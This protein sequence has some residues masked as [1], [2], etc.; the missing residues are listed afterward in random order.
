LRHVKED[1]LGYFDRLAVEVKDALNQSDVNVCSWCAEIWVAQY[2]AAKAARLI[3]NVRFVDDT[4]A[5][6]PIDGWSATYPQF[7]GAALLRRPKR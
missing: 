5:V 3:R 4:R 2:G 7:G 1:L 6:T